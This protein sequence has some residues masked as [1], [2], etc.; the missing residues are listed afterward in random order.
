MDAP[1][2]ILAHIRHAEGWL[3]K[4]RADYERGD[5]RQALLRLLLAEA[6]IRRA[7]ESG[8][9]TAA[10]PR[11]HS[12]VP[13]WAVLGTVVAA[14]ALMAAYAM[15]RP[16]A[17]GPIAN[18]PGVLPAAPSA[19]GRGGVLRFESGQVL[20]FVGIPAQ[21]RPSGRTGPGGVVGVDGDPLLDSDGPTLV[22]F[23]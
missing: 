2:G 19:E 9:A 5:G 22:T 13:A 4:A 8:V 1:C 21:V 10:I 23:R 7:R 6:E 15:V 3:R 17:S 18:A 14:V 20:P 11:R 12:A 16:P